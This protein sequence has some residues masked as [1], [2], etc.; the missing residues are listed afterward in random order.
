MNAAVLAFLAQIFGC[1]IN[2]C[3]YVLSKK[4]HLKTN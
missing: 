3:Y 1:F 4:A 2:S